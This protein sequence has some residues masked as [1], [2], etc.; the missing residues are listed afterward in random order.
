MANDTEDVK[1][2]NT[3]Y[4]NFQTTPIYCIFFVCT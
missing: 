3:N 1:K 4:K 2:M